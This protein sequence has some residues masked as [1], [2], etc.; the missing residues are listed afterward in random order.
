MLYQDT[1]TGMLHEAPDTQVSAL[2]LAEDPH[3]VGEAQM[4]YDGLGN[5]L[6]WGF[7]NK[8]IKKAMP[9][10]AMIPGPYGQIISRAIPIVRRALEPT[11]RA[12]QQ[13]V[14]QDLAPSPQ[15]AA[16]PVGYPY[17]R[18]GTYPQPFR[19]SSS[20][21]WRP[22]QTIYRPQ[23]RPYSLTP[24]RPPVAWRP[25][26]APQPA[27]YSRPP[28]PAGWKRPEVP[29]TG[30]KPR[31]VYMRCAVWRG[32]G[33]LVPVNPGQTP[34]VMPAAAAVAPPPAVRRRHRH[35]R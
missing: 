7:L 16:V 21:A 26:Q 33:G 8:L 22:P 31:R 24:V 6:G 17:V 1:L 18:P 30:P 19:S 5:P 2:E 35:R 34:M 20:I 29:Y 25:P 14:Q 15:L 11:A 13:Q 4:V 9:L 32:P 27:A 28:W 23:P 12:L 3:G 10:A